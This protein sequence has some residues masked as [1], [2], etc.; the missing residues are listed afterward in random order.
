MALLIAGMELPRTAYMIQ[1][2]HI[3]LQQSVSTG[4]DYSTGSGVSTGSD[5]STGSGSPVWGENSYF[6]WGSEI[7]FNSFFKKDETMLGSSLAESKH[8]HPVRE[9]DLFVP[10]QIPISLGLMAFCFGGI[11]AFPKM[12]TSMRKRSL[13][14]R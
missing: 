12:Y 2:Q 7:W 13:Y 14:P 8:L 9:Y 10:S 6:L 1:S 5:Y 4:S 3:F 11:G